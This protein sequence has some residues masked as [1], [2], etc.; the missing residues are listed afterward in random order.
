MEFKNVARRSSIL[1]GERHTSVFSRLAAK[2]IDALVVVAIFFLG[3]TLLSNVG[4]ALA[5]AFSAV[6]DGLGDGQS[7]GKRIMGLRVVDDVSGASCNFRNSF[8]RNFPFT[9]AVIF[10]TVPA[11]WVFFILLTLP[12]LGLE[13]YLLFTVDSGIRLGDV[14]GNTLVVE[15]LDDSFD[16]PESKLL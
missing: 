8:L 10:V 12:V 13:L 14:L 16:M 15:Y 4:L 11:L 6:Q 7:I 1:L 5:A 2:V 3:E 9:L